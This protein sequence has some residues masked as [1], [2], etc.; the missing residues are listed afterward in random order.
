[1]SEGVGEWEGRVNECEWEG[2]VSVCAGG[3]EKG[4]G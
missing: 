4:Y 3:G 1:M 2:G